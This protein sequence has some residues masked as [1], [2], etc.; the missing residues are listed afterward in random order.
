MHLHYKSSLL[1]CLSGARS[2]NHGAG[3]S[4][5]RSCTGS[6]VEL[7]ALRPYFFVSPL[8]CHR[9][10]LMMHSGPGPAWCLSN[11]GIAGTSIIAPGIA[12]G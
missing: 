1:K 6:R 9:I 7:L 5:G 2:I 3:Q 4:P 12:P 10:Q 11:L 8:F